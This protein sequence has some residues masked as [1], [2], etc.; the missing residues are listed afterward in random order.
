[1][2]IRKTPHLFTKNEFGKNLFTLGSGTV[3]AQII[4][5]LFYPVIA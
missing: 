5:F 4:P 1:M 2:K 3:L